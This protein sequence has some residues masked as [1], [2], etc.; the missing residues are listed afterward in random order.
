MDKID[1]V[2]L[3]GLVLAKGIDLIEALTGEEI[4]PV[5]VGNKAKG[6]VEENRKLRALA[7]EREHGT[8]TEGLDG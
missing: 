6:Y 8:A 2:K 4:D 5:E 3:G 7:L 1:W